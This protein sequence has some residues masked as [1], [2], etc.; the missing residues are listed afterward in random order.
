VSVGHFNDAECICLSR[1]AIEAGMTSRGISTVDVGLT[2]SLATVPATVDRK[3]KGKRPASDHPRQSRRKKQTL[4]TSVNRFLDIE[5]E[6]G[7]DDDDHPDID[8]EDTGS[9]PYLPPH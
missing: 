9:S 6:D 3:G 8:G 4:S 1:A 2:V 5:A 7:D